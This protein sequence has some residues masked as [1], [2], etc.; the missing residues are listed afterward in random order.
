MPITVT[1]PVQGD[2][3]GPGNRIVASSSLGVIPDGAHW[4]AL[5]FTSGTSDRI[6]LSALDFRNTPSIEL[7]L[8]VRTD[9]TGSTPVWDYLDA[10]PAVG[11]EHEL[12]VR[13]ISAQSTILDASGPI[14]IVY[15]PDPWGVANV[16]RLQTTASGS[17]TF[18]EEDR[19]TAQKTMALASFPLGGWIPS[20]L[21]AIGDLAEIPYQYELI[22]PDRT[23]GGVLTRPGPGV[24]V[25]AIGLRYQIMAKPPGIGTDEGAPPSY[26]LPLLELGLTRD[27]PGDVEIT[28]DSAWFR[29]QA[30]EWR[31]DFAFPY[32][33]LYWIQPGVLVRFWW[34]KLPLTGMLQA[35]G[36]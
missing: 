34:I 23:G 31:W 33:V 24:N 19:A 36:P 27:A 10:F 32:Q 20:M 21:D 12:H 14:G 35:S 17:G 1:I 29:D 5:I 26:E 22:T 25:F 13:L 16:A 6:L 2:A 15:R 3:V 9:T 30:G 4:D 11:A 28:V 8:G 18:T 7:V